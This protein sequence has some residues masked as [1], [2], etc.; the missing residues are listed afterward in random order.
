VNHFLLQLQELATRSRHFALLATA[1][2]EKCL[3]LLC[4]S[5]LQLQ[6]LA[7]RSRHFALLVTA[8]PEK[9]RTLLCKSLSAAARE[10][11]THTHTYTHTLLGWAR[12]V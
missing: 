6:E 3:K 1:A 7:T 11:A 8:A 5:V 12:T 9:C 2:P 4:K 10:L